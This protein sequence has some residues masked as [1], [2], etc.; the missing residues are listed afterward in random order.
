MR[1]ATIGWSGGAVDLRAGIGTIVWGRLDEVQPTDVI[2][3]L[4]ASKYLLAGRA[5][6]RLPVVHARLRWYAGEKA[7]IEGVWVPLFT[8]GR[9]DVLD[10]ASSPFNLLADARRCT[11]SPA[12][13][14]VSQFIRHEPPRSSGSSQGGARVS[15]T[16][17][18]VDWALAVYSGY[19][20]FGRIGVGPIGLPPGTPP[21]FIPP[22]LVFETYPRFTM[23]GGDFETVRGDWAIRGE[24]ALTTG[25][26]ITSAASP[27][28]I[29]GHSDPRRCRRRSAGRLVSPQRHAPRRARRDPA[30]RRRR[31]QREP[32]RRRRA[33]VRARHP[34]G[35]R[36]RRLERRRRSGFAR[37]IGTWSLRDNLALE[38]TVG[39]F[40]GHGDDTISRF[41]GSRLRRGL[42]EGLLLMA[43]AFEVTIAT[44]AGMP[45][46]STDDRLLA[47]AIAAAGA[48]GRLAVW[49]DAGVDWAASRLTVIRST[50]DY[51][52]DPAGW[53]AWLDAASAVTRLVNAAPILRWNSDK[54]YLLE[55]ERAG[56]PIVPTEHASRG[57]TA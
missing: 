20:G 55:L 52:L 38:G 1:E 53:F 27:I 40:F 37:T 45:E 4:D 21:D 30:S 16:S 24:A 14:P 46:G 13:P 3:P 7:T 54:R 28:G 50:W 33:P 6:A 56:V 42:A 2:N 29:E 19:P 10:E 51:H 22:V 48:R 32:R 23:Y 35:A 17:G 9:Y 44:H 5:D 15:I 57:A 36:L 31:H 49:N 12:C 26:T 41:R 18:R 11:P 8:R 39:W 47:Q 43:A 25:D 34:Q